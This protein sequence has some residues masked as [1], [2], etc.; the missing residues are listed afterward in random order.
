MTNQEEQSENIELKI[1]TLYNT[2]ISNSLINEMIQ[3][4]KERNYT[5]DRALEVLEA[6]SFHKGELSVRLLTELVEGSFVDREQTKKMAKDHIDKM[7]K[8]MNLT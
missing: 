2:F 3:L 5:S 1:S 4:M 7:E 6:Y 8:G